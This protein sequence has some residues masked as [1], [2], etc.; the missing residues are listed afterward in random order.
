MTETT[1]PQ[2]IVYALAASPTFAADGVCFAA[3]DSGLFR[4]TDGGQ[5][6]HSAYDSLNP[7]EPL[8]TMAVAVSPNFSDDS[9]VLA[10]VPGGIL[11]SIDGGDTWQIIQLPD[12]A[13]VVIS[14]VFSPHY[15]GDGVVW[16]GTLEDGVFLSTNRG[17]KW[18]LWNFGLID[19]HILCLAPS[20][21]FAQDQTIF[22][23][24]ESGIFRS[25]NSGKS[26]QQTG[27]P[28]DAAPVLSLAL[29]PTFAEDGF[30]WAGTES[31]GLFYSEDAGQNW[32]RLDEILAESAIN[33]IALSP[34]FPAKPHILLLVED[35]LL[36]SRDKGQSWTNAQTIVDLTEGVST[37]SVPQGLEPNDPLLLGLVEKGIARSKIV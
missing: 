10:G 18:I 22:A 31:R 29:S 17:Q 4:S 15:A 19:C 1:T 35:N 7:T 8:T 21:T 3:R 20:A 36:L 24:T 25:R 34:N 13:P 16:A 27:F 23:G 9:T 33:D 11:R 14:L 12:P 32:T 26:W 30:I 5:T 2:D 6:W 37:S 28:P